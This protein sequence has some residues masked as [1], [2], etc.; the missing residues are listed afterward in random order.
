MDGQVESHEFTE[1]WVLV[2]Q[3]A[4][5]VRRPVLAGV[6][7]ADTGAVAV[8]VAVDYGGDRR[9]LRNEIH[10]VLIHCLQCKPA[11]GMAG[12]STTGSNC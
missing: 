9:Q 3:H 6:N 7:G 4:D 5:K 8:K 11:H 12:P 10:A 2:A 1:L